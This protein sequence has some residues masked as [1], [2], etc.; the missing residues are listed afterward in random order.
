MQK[1]VGFRNISVHE[2]Q[3]IDWLIVFKIITEHL[4][5][6]EKFAREVSAFE[7]VGNR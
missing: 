6:F 3:S 2:Y 4:V 1:S 5:D 7:G